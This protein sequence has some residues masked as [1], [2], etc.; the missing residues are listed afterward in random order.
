MLLLIPLGLG[1]SVLEHFLR[2]AKIQQRSPSSC[3][4]VG[5]VTHLATVV[6]RDA[7]EK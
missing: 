2:S 6:L 4:C 7:S 3:T 5:I 1:I